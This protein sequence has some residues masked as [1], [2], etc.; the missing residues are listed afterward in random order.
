MAELVMEIGTG[1]KEVVDQLT[2]LEGVTATTTR[3]FTG[4]M[5]VAL[6]IGGSIATVLVREIAKIVMGRQA[7]IRAQKL[8]I[9]KGTISF[10][11]FSADQ[12]GSLIDTLIKADAPD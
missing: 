4:E 9:G 3:N 1:S 10:E 5:I 2:A 6:S 7:T 8:K 12:I 11:G